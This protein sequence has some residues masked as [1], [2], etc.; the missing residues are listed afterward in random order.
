[1]TRLADR[2]SWA[3]LIFFLIYLAAHVLWALDRWVL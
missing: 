2:L 3:V 1:M